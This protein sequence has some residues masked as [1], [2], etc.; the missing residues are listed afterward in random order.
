MAWMR[1]DYV[2]DAGMMKTHRD[3]SVALPGDVASRKYQLHM[4]VNPF[5]RDVGSYHLTS[6]P[7][8][9][10]QA[11]CCLDAARMGVAWASQTR[12]CLSYATS[13]A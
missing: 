4:E 3:Q 6:A 9:G 8:I 1:Y 7:S 11:A 2:V 10:G 13:C 12:S 5:C